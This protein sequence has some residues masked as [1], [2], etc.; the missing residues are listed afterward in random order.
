MKIIAIEQDIPDTDWNG[1][2]ALLAD[3]ARHVYELYTKNIV[4]EIYF[5]EQHHAVLMLE[6]DCKEEAQR[7]VNTF[8]LVRSGLIRFQLFELHPYTGLER[9]FV[10]AYK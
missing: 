8:P 4:R 3:E 7:I 2:E 1:K 10:S 9:L 5:T 6:C